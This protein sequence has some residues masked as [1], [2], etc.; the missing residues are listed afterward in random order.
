MNIIEI[1]S[2]LSQDFE[3][4]KY[5]SLQSGK[6]YVDEKFPANNSSISLIKKNSKPYKVFW[7]RP[8]EI[9]DAPKFTVNSIKPSDIVQGD[10]G[11]CW[12]ISAVA[13]LAAIPSYFR[14]VV[15]NSQTFDG[16]SYA[17]IFH[18]RFWHFGEW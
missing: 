6:L 2:Y 5:L 16:P 3:Q 10:T 13:T 7:K 1:K 17:G 14:F 4:L 18:F 8:H 15:P 12:F 9:S 11:N